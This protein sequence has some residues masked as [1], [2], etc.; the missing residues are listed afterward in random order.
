MT[1]AL[2]AI[3]SELSDVLWPDF[4]RREL[5]EAISDDEG[6]TWSA[7]R[8]RVFAGIDINRTELWIDQLRTFKDFHGK[9]LD[10]NNLD[11]CDNDNQTITVGV[12]VSSVLAATK[13]LK[14]AMLG[15]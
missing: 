2:N 9:L 7:P 3:T 1:T 4:G 11:S 15:G 10:E 12:N 5:Y 8:P 6:K 14:K 13:A